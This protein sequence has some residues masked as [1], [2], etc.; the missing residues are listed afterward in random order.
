MA[1]Q[2]ITEESPTPQRAYWE[3]VFRARFLELRGTAFQDFFSELMEFR[4]PD[5]FQRI[6]PWGRHGDRKSDGYLGSQR[7][8]FQV[9]A[10]AEMA[11]KETIKKIDADFAGCL[12]Y[13]EEYFHT[14]TFVHNSYH[15]LPADVFHRLQELDAEQKLNLQV[16]QW[17]FPELR[18]VCFELEETDLAAFLGSAPTPQMMVDLGYEEIQPVIEAVARQRPAADAEVLPV[19]QDKINANGLSPDVAELL[20]FGMIRSQAVRKFLAR[21]Y[22]A[23]LGDATAETFRMKYQEL[24]ATMNDPDGIFTAL[25]R[26]TGGDQKGLAE[27]EAAVL[28][29]LAY[30]FEECDIFERPADAPAN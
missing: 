25:W 16:K 22:D 12:P 24:Q 3:A 14:W 11:A 7:T 29:V 13:W 27:R 19:P 23:T 1:S 18:N 9:Y 26:F 5:D 30:F 28:A 10:P 6:L 21:H 2:F 20:K 17:G 8:V 4:F 15:G